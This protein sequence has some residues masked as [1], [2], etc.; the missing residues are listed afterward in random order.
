MSVPSLPA[1][2]SGDV[3]QVQGRPPGCTSSAAAPA[4]EEVGSLPD[5]KAPKPHSYSFG[6]TCLPEAFKAGA[7]LRNASPV[8]GCLYRSRH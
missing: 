8:E 2:H 1:L 3:S 7:P 5:S 4:A 6:R